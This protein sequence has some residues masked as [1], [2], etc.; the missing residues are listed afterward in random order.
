MTDLRV[1][2]RAKELLLRSLAALIAIL[3]FTLI[4]QGRGTTAHAQTPGFPI[5]SS[6]LNTQISGPIAV[7]GKTQYNI[8]GGTRTNNGPNLFHSFGEFGVPTSNIANFLNETALPTSNILGRVTGGNISNIFGTI[9]TTGFGNANLFLMNPAGFLFGPHATVNVGGMIAFTT[10]DYLRLTDNVRFNAVPNA[11]ADALLSAAPVAAFG[12]LGSNPGAIT[13]QGSQLSVANGPNDTG[14]SLVGGNITLQ[15]G[16]LDDGTVQPARLSASSGQINL[17]SVASPG[18]VLYPSLQTG[19]NINGQSFTNMGN[20]SLSQGATLD[21]SADA[22]GTVKIRGG[23]FVM[24]NTTISADT[25]NANG[26]PTAVDI[27]L[28]GD[29]SIL[30]DI[31]PAITARTTGSGNAGEIRLNSAKLDVDFAFPEFGV[32]IDSSTVGSGN[33]GKVTVTTG[34]LTATN[35]SSTVFNAFIDSGTG[36]G[37]NGGDVTIKV[38]NG[39]FLGASINTGDAFF[40]GTGSAGNLYIGGA[41]SKADSLRFNATPLSTEAFSAKAGSIML[42][43]RDI[44]IKNNT[45]VS[46]ISLL[47]E[48]PITIEA[49]R[50]VMDNVVRVQGQT[51]GLGNGGDIVFRGQTLE[52]TNESAFLTQT[53]G[54]GNAGAIRVLANDHVLIA[55]DPLISTPSG[56]FTNSFGDQGFGMTGKSGPIEVTTH[57]LDMMGGARFSTTSQSGGDGGNVTVMAPE[58]I[59]ISGQRIGGPPLENFGLGGSDGSGIYTRTVGNEFCGGPCGKAG[60]QFINTG[61]LVLSN[62]GTLDSGTTSTGAG[63]TIHV[64][65]T[66][67]VLISGTLADGTPGGIFSRT[68]GTEPGSGG[69]GDIA[70]IAGQSV[71]LNNR[72]SVSASSTGPA[73]AGN[74]T[75]NVGATFLMENSSVTTQAAQAGGGDISVMAGDMIRLT[76]SQINTSVAGGEGGGG[77]ITIDPNFVILQNSQ[78]L[79][80][81]FA[82]QGGNITI[83]TGTFLPDANSLVD[84]SSQFGLSGTV[85]IQSPTSNLS[86]V[87]ARLQQNYAEAAALLRARCAAQVSG[88]YSSFVVAGRDSLPLEPGGWLP[89]PMAALSAGEGRVARGEE[90]VVPETEFVSLRGFD[91]D[92]SWAVVGKIPSRF[93][94]VLDSACGS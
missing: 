68:V 73:N 4:E 84:A 25:V 93:A 2:F 38:R 27:Q 8:T 44:L 35:N 31:N 21:V 65:A 56:L 79:A 26:A 45:F 46:S 14:I 64:N 24:D 63:G 67:R 13:V 88:H 12:F 48:N 40:F 36:G 11:A 32:V 28:T 7:G 16:T 90:N 47:G 50:L 66:N 49:D 85:T 9:Q 62:G 59:F 83:T 51:L 37:G 94:S 29:L 20:I 53:F 30:A 54:D 52:M 17:A 71:T 91:Q 1:E 69:G 33:A 18:E 78:I 60:D 42:E 89:S 74:I 15:S 58:G 22:A 76:N 41:N 10:A 75:I 23:Q 80:Q 77:N 39:G 70:V 92:L 87:W 43:G 5:T 3:C 34:D 72:A 81:A 61:L 86:A 6:G 82:G 55:D 57:R 19:P